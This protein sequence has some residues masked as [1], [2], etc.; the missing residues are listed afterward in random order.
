[1]LSDLDSLMRT[2]GIDAMIVP[3]HESSHAAFRWISRGAK[4]TRGYVVKLLD[5]APLLLAYPMERDEAAATGLTTRLIHD[6]GYDK[7]FKSAPNQ[8][9]AYATFFDAVLRPARI[10]H[11]DFVRRQCAIPLVLRRRIG[12]A[13]ARLEGVSERRRGPR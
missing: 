9:D 2:R 6:F 5:R 13:A 3:M 4:V 11:S 12:D 7:I 8:V 1:M 10:G